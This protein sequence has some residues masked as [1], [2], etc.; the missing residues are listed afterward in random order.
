MSKQDDIETLKRRITL[1]EEER[2]A[3]QRAGHEEDYLQAYS[4]VEALEPQVE[5]TLQTPQ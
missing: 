4:M 1:A 2:D 5:A 3:L